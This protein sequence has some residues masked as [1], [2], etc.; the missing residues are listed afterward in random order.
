MTVSDSDSAVYK[1]F[2]SRVIISFNLLNPNLFSYTND[3]FLMEQHKDNE[4]IEKQRNK[5][6]E[7]NFRMAFR[8]YIFE[9][10][11]PNPIHFLSKVIIKSIKLNVVGNVL[12]TLKH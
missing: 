8:A 6:L 11:K 10:R 2:Y 1:G 12:R 7:K 4:K 3:S 9:R 5:D